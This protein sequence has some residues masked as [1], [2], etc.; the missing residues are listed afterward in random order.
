MA[1]G[2]LGAAAT[3]LLLC[4]FILAAYAFGALAFRRGWISSNF[5]NEVVSSTT[6]LPFDPARPL[7]YAYEVLLIWLP[8]LLA[9]LIVLRIVH[10][11]S[12]RRA[13]S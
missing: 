6:M 8:L 4:V 5:I 9:P 3:V 2:L 1:V 11:V 10:G 7:S 13:F 12:W